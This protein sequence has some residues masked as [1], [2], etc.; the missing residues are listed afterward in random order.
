MSLETAMSP[1]TF[2]VLTV[3]HSA[4]T[5]E[6]FIELLEQYGVTAVADVRTTPYSKFNPA[7]NLECIKRALQARGIA[8]IFLGRELGARSKDPACY[9][10]GRVKYELLAGTDAFRRGVDRVAAGASRYHIALMCAEGE[11]LRCH[12]TLLV[13]RVLAERGIAVRHIHTN[14]QLESHEA[15]MSRLLDLV[16]LPQTDLFRSRSD[17]L[18]EGLLLQEGKVA[19][20]VDRT[21]NR[22]RAPVAAVT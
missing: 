17:L 7:F 13:A 11:P 20:H 8:Y 21:R 4:H 2:P 9:V 14:G 6:R 3:G 22:N 12:R 19:Y 18:H 15:A 1:K 16:G 10:D 5:A